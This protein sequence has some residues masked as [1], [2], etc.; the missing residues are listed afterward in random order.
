M[1]GIVPLH[2]Q[3]P[4][5]ILADGNVTLQLTQVPGEHGMSA[6]DTI[7]ETTG[8][9]LAIF[10]VS[11]PIP[12]VWQ[13]QKTPAKV[14]LINPITILSIY[15]NCSAQVVYGVFRPL[16]A[17]VPCNLYGLVASMYYLASC[18]WCA[19][20][21]R[22]ALHWNFAAAVATGCA[23]LGSVLMWLYAFF[24]VHQNAAEHVGGLALVLNVLVF[25][26][27]LSALKQVLRDR[28]SESL[29]PLQSVLGLLCS[30]CWCCV[31]LR[32]QSMPLWVPNVLG[33]LLS[34]VQ[35]VLI[36]AYPRAGRKEIL[37]DDALRPHV[38]KTTI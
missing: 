16:P 3:S 28:S 6:A 13:A 5:P 17:S 15:G 11:S 27:P 10:F 36:A 38:C 21:F 26:A 4:T 24:Q 8:T 33:I 2:G 23:A 35:L 19:A 32:H 14:D 1:D 20:K 22:S 18:W 25:A 31:G 37:F 29:P 30:T 34:A 7:L 9:I 12:Q